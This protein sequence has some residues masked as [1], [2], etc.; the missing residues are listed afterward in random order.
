M[1]RKP[2]EPPKVCHRCEDRFAVHGEKYCKECKKS[3]LVELQSAGYLSDTKQPKVFSDE[4]GRKSLNPKVLG[5]TAEFG[6][7]GDIW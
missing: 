5:G 2:K 6:T 4:R 3:V 1:P 7:D